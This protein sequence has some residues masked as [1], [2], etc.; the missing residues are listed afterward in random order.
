MITFNTRCFSRIKRSLLLLLLISSVI[1]AK[2]LIFTYSY[3]RPDFIELQEKSFKK[4]LADDYE[5]VVFNDARD[6]NMSRQIFRTC[7]RLGVQCIKIPQAIHD[8]PYLQRWP[9]EDYNHPTVRNCNVVQYSLDIMGFNHNDILVLFDSDVFLIKKFN[10]REFLN[11]YDMGG[12]ALSINDRTGSGPI[13]YLWHGLAFLDMHSMPNRHTLSF[14]CGKVENQSI[15]AGGHSY[16]YLK[17]NP[18]LKVKWIEHNYI[19][20]LQCNSCQE[21][22]AYTCTHN[23]DKLREAGFD[24][25]QIPFIQKAPAEIEFYYNNSFVHYRAGCNWNYNTQEYLDKK[26]NAFN[27]FLDVIGKNNQ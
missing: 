9:T 13:R 20:E 14:N 1:H 2:I 21:S 10:V 19:E 26:T 22:K 27:E 11:G 8:K 15:D 12:R 16:Y 17:N 5:F 3:N 4:F 23:A 6:P 18:G 25:D 24:E 7:N